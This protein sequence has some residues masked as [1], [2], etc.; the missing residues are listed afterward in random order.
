MLMY[1][2]EGNLAASIAPDVYV[3]LDYDLGERGMN[4]FWEAGKPPDFALEVISRS[5][6]LRNSRDKRALYVRLG[7]E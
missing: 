4:K 3:V 7:I 2:E 6:K 1:Y 5:S